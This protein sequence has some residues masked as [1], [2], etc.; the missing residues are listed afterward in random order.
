MICSWILETLT[1]HDFIGAHN[2]IDRARLAE[3][4][5]REDGP[6]LLYSASHFGALVVNTVA[7]SW[8]WDSWWCLPF[9][10]LQGVLLN[11]LYAPEHECDHFTAFKTRWLNV[12]VGRLCGFLIFFSNEYHRWSHYHHHRNTQDWDDDPE[13]MER[14]VFKTPWQYVMGL[15]GYRALWVGRLKVLIDHTRGQVNEPYLTAPQ[16]KAVVRVARGYMTGYGVVAVLALGMQSWWPIYYWIGP[17]LVMRWTYWLQ[18]LGEHTGL[19][20]EPN[21]LWNT[22]TLKTNAFMRW[23]NWNMTY[24]T[25]HHTFPSVPFY[26]LPV[27]HR[28]VEAKLGYALPSAPYFALHWG[29]LKAL[30]SGK[31][32]LDICADHERAVVE[33]QLRTKR[34]TADAI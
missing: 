2:V 1:M 33:M 31:T 3:L 6:A 16:R 23:V 13:L 8:T 9:F 32:E 7:M 30:A 12:W 28:E 18:G 5:Q 4:S 17:F 14:S 27:L 10:L 19:T 20:H 29:H 25:V 22:R 26:R 34:S 15:L 24:H 11:F 21:T